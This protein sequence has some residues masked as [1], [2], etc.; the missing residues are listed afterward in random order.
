MVATSVG[1]AAFA[2]HALIALRGLDPSRH[3][4]GT[5]GTPGATTAAT[6]NP[7]SPRATCSP[8]RHDLLGEQ[9]HCHINVNAHDPGGHF[10]PWENPEA[11]VSDLR[12]TFNGRRP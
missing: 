8:P 9:L 5:S 10:I 7:S 11:W 3:V 12:R 2:V 1:Y 4:L 6:S